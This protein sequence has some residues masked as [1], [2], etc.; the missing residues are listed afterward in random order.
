MAIF[1][2][3]ILRQIRRHATGA[4]CHKEQILIYLFVN[5]MCPIFENSKWLP[6]GHLDQHEFQLGPTRHQGDSMC[7]I[8]ELRHQ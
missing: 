3:S 4:E 8:S 5:E 1:S 2:F 6:G 7:E